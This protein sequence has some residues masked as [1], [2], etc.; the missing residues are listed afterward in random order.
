MPAIL[1]VVERLRRYQVQASL[2]N[3]QLSVDIS[4]FGWEWTEAHVSGLL[5]GKIKPNEE[6]QEFIARYLAK[7]YYG[8]EFA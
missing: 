5:L 2:S 6:H 1:S 3:L 7:R 8:V 4:N